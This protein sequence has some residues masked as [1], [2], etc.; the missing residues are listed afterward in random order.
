MVKYMHHISSL[1][2]LN[3]NDILWYELLEQLRS[4]VPYIDPDILTTYTPILN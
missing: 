1:R 2:G 4:T 3:P